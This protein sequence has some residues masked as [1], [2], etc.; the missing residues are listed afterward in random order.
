M[1]A[2]VTPATILAFTSLDTFGFWHSVPT[3]SI[4]LPVLGL[5]LIVLG[6]ALMVATIRLFVTVGQ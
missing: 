6:L 5:F 1:A 4:V 3:T 2:V